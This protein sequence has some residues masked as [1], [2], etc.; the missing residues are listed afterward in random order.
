M[1][2]KSESEEVFGV[3]LFLFYSMDSKSY[4]DYMLNGQLAYY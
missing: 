1:W 3:F 4:T 2:S